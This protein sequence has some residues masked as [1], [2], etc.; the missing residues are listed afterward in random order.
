MK[1]RPFL[2]T[3]GLNGKPFGQ[4]ILPAVFSAPVRPDII[5]SVHTNL[6]KNRR[7]P[8]AVSTKAGHASAARSWGTGRAVARVPRVH[9]GGTQRSGQGAFGNM[10]R[11]G[12]IYAPTKNWRR[13]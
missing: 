9:G 11:G 8:Y 3:F 2:S 10:C 1:A 12:H 7:Q 13:W 6:S 5:Q 4:I